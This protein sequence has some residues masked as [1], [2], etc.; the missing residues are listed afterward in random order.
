MRAI[1]RSV[2]FYVLLIIFAVV[3]NGCASML[4]VETSEQ[5]TKRM[6]EF[7][8]IQEGQTAWVNS[9]AGPVDPGVDFSGTWRYPE[10]GFE[11]TIHQVDNRLHVLKSGEKYSETWSINHS[12][13][14]FCG[15]YSKT[16]NKK[17]VNVFTIW[18]ATLLNSTTMQWNMEQGTTV[19]AYNPI[20]RSVRVWTFN[21][22]G[23]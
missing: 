21:R 11:V 8:D 22:I 2:S 14:Y 18:R 5:L 10:T 19:G 23:D 20:T 13:A 1:S 16:V 15:F 4:R 9:M 12:T 17:V 7:F 6:L 3:I